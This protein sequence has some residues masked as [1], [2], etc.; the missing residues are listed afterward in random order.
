M[1]DYKGF[2]VE[3]QFEPCTVEPPEDGRDSMLRATDVLADMG[4]AGFQSVKHFPEWA[5]LLDFCSEYKGPYR[6]SCPESRK[7][8][9]SY[10]DYLRYPNE[11]TIHMHGE[12]TF[13]SFIEERKVQN[14]LLTPL[15][16][17]ILG[18]VRGEETYAD[19]LM[20]PK[21]Q[22]HSPASELF[23]AH[24]RIKE[25]LEA[26]D[27]LSFSSSERPILE[28]TNRHEIQQPYR[29]G[30]D[31]GRLLGRCKYAFYDAGPKKD[32]ARRIWD[33]NQEFR[34]VLEEHGQSEPTVAK[35]FMSLDITLRVSW[36]CDYATFEK[37][38]DGDP[39]GPALP[40]I[41]ESLDEYDGRLEVA[42]L[43]IVQPAILA[44]GVLATHYDH[45]HR[46]KTAPLS[47]LGLSEPVLLLLEA[48]PEMRYRLVDAA[49]C[50]AN[51]KFSA[52]AAVMCPLIEQIVRKKYIKVIGPVPK[53]KFSS[54]LIKELKELP[55]AKQFTNLADHL[56]P[57]RNVEVHEMKEWTGA[58]ARYFLHAVCLLLE[59]AT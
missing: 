22:R 47:V 28:L 19:E 13:E 24:E 23:D 8:L 49:N 33:L 30:H 20:V 51:C 52:A 25:R 34:K 57:I 40:R 11:S 2:E 32:R 7:R 42:L 29:V 50:I 9:P 56:R 43:E 6:S 53:K 38:M 44:I 21:A 37:G 45:Q 27:G 48:E 15:E 54:D 3:W 4:K 18:V 41:I 55:D 36:Q 12:M 17:F 31:C 46:G 14:L 10:T 16:G 1:A 58:E 35:A 59:W 5:S 39:W 26:L